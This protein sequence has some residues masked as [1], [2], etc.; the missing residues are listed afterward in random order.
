MR[1]PCQRQSRA[2]QPEGCP[3]SSYDSP[4]PSRRGVPANSGKTVKNKAL[5]LAIHA[6]AGACTV[7]KVAKMHHFGQRCGKEAALKRI[8]V[9]YHGVTS[10]FPLNNRYQNNPRN[11]HY[12]TIPRDFLVATA[13]QA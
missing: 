9:V 7:G 12:D 4:E 8:I 5:T 13:Q 3:A 6:F 2:I 11:M 1:R 10:L